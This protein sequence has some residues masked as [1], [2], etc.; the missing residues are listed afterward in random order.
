MKLDPTLVEALMEDARG[1]DTLPL[2]AFTLGRLAQAYG[3]EGKLTLAQYERLGRIS[4]A[5]T[6]AVS[7]ALAEGTR[8]GL[9]ARGKA[10]LDDLLRR[11]FIPHLARVNKAGQFVRRVAIEADLPARSRAVINLFVEARLLL[12]D[13][14]PVRDGDADIIEVAHEALLR[15]WPALREWL[16]ADREFLIGKEKVAESAAVWRDATLKQKKDALLSGLNLARARQW[17]HDRDTQDLTGEEHAFIVASIAHDEAVTRRKRQAAVAAFAIL[18]AF[19]GVAASQWIK[20]ERANN[21]AADRLNLARNGAEDLVKF[22]VTDLRNI[23]GIQTT[24]LV[25]VLTTAKTS[26]DKLSDAVG[27]DPIFLEHRAK[28]M[29]EFGEAFLKARGLDRARAAYD[30]SLNIYTALAGK[31]PRAIEWQRGIANQIDNIG[32][33][34]QQE[35]KLDAA[36]DSFRRA[37]ALRVLIAARDP[38]NA[39]SYRDLAS[40]HYNVGEI[41]MAAKKPQKSLTSHTVALANTQRALS[42]DANNHDLESKLSVIQVSLAL[43]YSALGSSGKQRQNNLDALAIRKHLHEV[44]P[45]NA[46][47]T[48]LLAWAYYWVGDDYLDNKEPDEALRNYQQCLL[49]RQKLAAIDPSN[50]VLKYD[51]AWAHYAMGAAL[52]AQGNPTD[53]ERSFLDA[54]NLFKQLVDTDA[55]NARWRRGL[56]LTSES[57]GDVAAAQSNA[58]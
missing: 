12:R 26:F 47:W 6:A 17:L 13:R 21:V 28:M 46:D 44:A 31:D 57:L 27:D 54:F 9:L 36:L 25:R 50:F 35:G 43:A 40:S 51:L 2:L 38:D 48:R 58:R 11:T 1:E 24:T 53:A 33:V 3:A 49:L 56:A 22:I 32:V 29:S 15:E 30:E 8:L 37:L 7:E 16:E 18:L 52:K 41:M 19:A 10:T 39:I 55:A 20:A 5:V 42:I 23:Q 34:L 45:D 14:R 4:G